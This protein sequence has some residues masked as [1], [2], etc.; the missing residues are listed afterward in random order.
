MACSV[1]LRQPTGQRISK[2]RKQ[3]FFFNSANLFLMSI[4][5]KKKSKKSKKNSSKS[6][7]VEEFTQL[8]PV[9]ES[10]NSGDQKL[11]NHEM[12]ALY[13]SAKLL[14]F[15]GLI[16]SNLIVEEN[17]EQWWFCPIFFLLLFEVLVVPNRRAEFCL[18]KWFLHWIKLHQILQFLHYW[19]VINNVAI[20]M[21]SWKKK[22]V[23]TCDIGIFSVLGKWK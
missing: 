2:V 20:A 23:V 11:W 19:S 4:R 3:R 21:L 12:W 13:D 10:R 18:A 9:T 17:I 6:W 22:Y 8:R 1:L 14:E 15:V 5:I 7:N 16:E